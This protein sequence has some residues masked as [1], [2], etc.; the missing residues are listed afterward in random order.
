LVKAAVSA[1]KPGIITKLKG[2]YAYSMGSFDSRNGIHTKP[3]FPTFLM[4]WRH[5]LRQVS[6]LEIGLPPENIGP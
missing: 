2:K 5:P 3:M 1:G 4:N 6:T